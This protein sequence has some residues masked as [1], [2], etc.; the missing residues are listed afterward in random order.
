MKFFTSSV[1]TFGLLFSA[2]VI[3]ALAVPAAAPADKRGA[4]T[5]V[6]AKLSSTL[7]SVQAKAA[8]LLAD[9]DK[10]KNDAT[11]VPLSQITDDF[12]AITDDL[13]GLI[14]YL[15]GLDPTGILATVGLTD[16][17]TFV[18]GLVGVVLSI[19]TSALSMV[20]ITGVVNLLVTLLQ[21]VLSLTSL[22]S[23]VPSVGS[24]IAN[25]TGLLTGLLAT[26]TSVVT[27]ATGLLAVVGGIV[28][29]ITGSIL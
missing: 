5:D 7:A 18:A 10:L 13:T 12:G 29:G 6:A 19:A 20:S 14:T 27:T 15:Q 23:S 24:A 17:T 16:I 26:A 1:F 25:L 4:V 28:D 9:L 22:L 11:S 3:S 21:T 2:P 8:P